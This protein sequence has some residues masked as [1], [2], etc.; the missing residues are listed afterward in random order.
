MVNAEKPTGDRAEGQGGLVLLHG[1][2][3]N[4]AA[5]E[6]FVD[7]RAPQLARRHVVAA[8]L[9][10]RA[11]RT[12][13]DDALRRDLR[14]TL[15]DIAGAQPRLVLCTCTTLGGL[16]EELGAEIGLCVHRIDRA[17]AEAALKAGHRIVVL[18]T[19]PT[20]LEPTANL[21]H[22]VAA[23]LAVRPEVR[24]HLVEDAW[25]LFRDGDLEGYYE[26]IA[27][28]AREMAG[29]ADVL[30]LAQA[31]MAPAKA[32]IG[33]LSATVLTSPE[34]GMARALTLLG[35]PPT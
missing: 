13:L 32:R 3:S 7:E 10:A 8:D 6:T 12:G 14:D 26:V 17:L 2:R 27:A 28:A 33:K 4:V 5:F 29:E 16:A 9:L 20:T 18:A 1:A 31:S 22:A 19:A 23:D 25:P 15:Q 24:V 34:P 35:A 11:E 21:I 30:V